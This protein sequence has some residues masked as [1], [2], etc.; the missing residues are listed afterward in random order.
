MRAKSSSV[1]S[2]QQLGHLGLLAMYLHKRLP[3]HGVLFF[4][5]HVALKLTQIILLT[6]H[7][8]NDSIFDLGAKVH[9]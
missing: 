5:P 1:M 4:I 7:G 6:T 3:I 8:L 9:S 2:C